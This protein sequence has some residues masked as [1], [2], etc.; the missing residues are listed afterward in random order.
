MFKFLYRFSI[1][2]FNLFMTDG[3]KKKS[4]CFYLYTRRDE[5]RP[6]RTI[7]TLFLFKNKNKNILTFVLGTCTVLHGH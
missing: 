2:Y 4:I 6:R 7:T 3:Y 5:L 1:Q